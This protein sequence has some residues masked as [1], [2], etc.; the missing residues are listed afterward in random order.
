MAT[1]D[2]NRLFD[3]LDALRNNLE[4]VVEDAKTLATEAG[5]FNG[6]LNKVIKEQITKYFVPAIEKL[7]NDDQTPGSV[8]G[9]EKFLGSVPLAMV[10]E[11]PSEQDVPGNIM[12]EDVNLANP[13]GMTGNG[14]AID[15]IPQSASFKNP[16]GTSIKEALGRPDEPIHR[17]PDE[18]DELHQYALKYGEHSVLRAFFKFALNRQGE[19]LRSFI[20]A[21]KSGRIEFEDLDSQKF[22]EAQKSQETVFSGKEWKTQ[23][24]SIDPNK[25]GKI[26]YKTQDYTSNDMYFQEKFAV[27]RTSKVKPSS[28]D[29]FKEQ[30]VAEFDDKDAAEDKAKVLNET[31]SPEEKEMFGT[32]YKVIESQGYPMQEAKGRG[33]KE[34]LD[35]IIAQAEEPVRESKRHG[36]K[37][38]LDSVKARKFRE[39][40]LGKSMQEVL[41][42]EI[43]AEQNVPVKESKKK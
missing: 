13:A 3:L 29:D 40:N 23:G 35:E 17:E 6:E 11:Q 24:K 2:P 27:V 15:A 33:M 28:S 19:L 42:A 1:K 20:E 43:A 9:L 30:C 16:E 39:D 10:R 21:V 38:A 14:A 12:P 41:D 32:E 37:E 25:A 8:I 7:I 36:M 31:V 4:S 22:G 5:Q 26:N 34:V 18:W